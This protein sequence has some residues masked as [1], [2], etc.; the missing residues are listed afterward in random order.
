MLLTNGE[1]AYYGQCNQAISYF[2]EI[3]YTCPPEFNPADFLID[4][5]V[6]S[7]LVLEIQSELVMLL[8]LSF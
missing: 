8:M 4:I 2:K 6:S 1:L 3:G 7:E 5:T